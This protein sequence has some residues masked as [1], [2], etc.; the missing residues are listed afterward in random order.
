[1]E[2]VIVTTKKKLTKAI[3]NQMPLADSFA[4]NGGVVLGK[5]L[6]VRQGFTS[7][8]L[9]EHHDNHYILPLNIKFADDNGMVARVYQ[10]RTLVEWKTFTNKVAKDQWAIQYKKII[11]ACINAQ[12]YI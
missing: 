12:I 9:I 1:M 4:M 11:R 10:G 7:V 2:I 3:I 8:A 6:N 5:L